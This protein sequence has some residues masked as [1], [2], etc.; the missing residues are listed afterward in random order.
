MDERA[1]ERGDEIRKS[2]ESFQ[3]IS[4]NKQ[5]AMSLGRGATK[6]SNYSTVEKAYNSKGE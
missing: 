3:W 6:D 1:E 4:H 2:T 5:C